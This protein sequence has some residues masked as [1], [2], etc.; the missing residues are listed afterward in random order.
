[1]KLSDLEVLV[2][3]MREHSSAKGIVDPNVEFYENDRDALKSA[4]VGTY[5]LRLAPDPTIVNNLRDH[6]V[7]RVSGTPEGLQKGDFSIPLICL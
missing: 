1:M 4:M 6:V 7:V 5:F 3:A 2:K